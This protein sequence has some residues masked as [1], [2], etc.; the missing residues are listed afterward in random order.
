MG[1]SGYILRRL[2]YGVILLLGVVVLNF[3]LIH[4]APG[5]PAEVIAGE[6]GGATE[7][8]M[9]RIRADYGLD[10][11]LIVQ[12]GGS[13]DANAHCVGVYDGHIYDMNQGRLPFSRANLDKCCVGDSVRFD[14]V[15]RA[16]R[17]EPKA[18][19]KKRKR[20]RGGAE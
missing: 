13:D 5:D 4:A 6:M 3:L 7:E 15:S 10:Q 11:P 17:I 1:A 9:A 12:L 8:M 19:S 18:G 2:G 16:M 14:H 20:R